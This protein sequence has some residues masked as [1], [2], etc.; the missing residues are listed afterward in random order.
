M[1]QHMVVRT[2]FNGV[3]AIEYVDGKPA[4]FNELAD[5]ELLA[6]QL[7]ASRPGEKYRVIDFKAK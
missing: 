1:E 6:L 7:R 2:C 5:A 4:V 3:H